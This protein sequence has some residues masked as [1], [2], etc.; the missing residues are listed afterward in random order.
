MA[1]QL[2]SFIAHGTT[3]EAQKPS[4]GRKQP[5]PKAEL[6]SFA[7]PHGER[8]AQER[9]LC[10]GGGAIGWMRDKQAA[11]MGNE[12]RKMQKAA[13]DTDA[14]ELAKADA[15]MLFLL[16]RDGKSTCGDSELGRE[17]A[18]SS[19][20]ALRDWLQQGVGRLF[21]VVELG[22]GTGSAAA[23]VIAREARRT[24][25]LTIAI[26]T[27]PGEAEGAARRQKAL[28]GLERLTASAD[29]TIVVD[30]EQTG[31]DEAHRIML[32]MLTDLRGLLA[33]SPPSPFDWGSFHALFHE[34]GPTFVLSAQARGAGRIT[35]ALTQI[36]AS[37]LLDGRNIFTAERLHISIQ[38][39]R[40]KL[41]VGEM[42]ECREW[43]ARFSP[44]VE[45]S[46]TMHTDEELDRSARIIVI[47]ARLA[48]RATQA[49]YNPSRSARDEDSEFGRELYYGAR[50]TSPR[51][52]Y[53]FTP[54]SLDNDGVI[55]LVAATPTYLRRPKTITQINQ[56][57]TKSIEI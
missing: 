8:D 25:L 39:G 45:L 14:D 6:L 31:D 19:L 21:M 33:T 30:K 32:Q 57:A 17:L 37:P 18:E 10:V 34:A 48:A 1:E 11:I 55:E 38:T 56:I 36:A 13:V 40:N 53:R 42:D 23:A 43:L 41:L 16:G 50:T 22:G 27:L 12:A 46:Y 28:R 9:L 24:G 51:Y 29:A 35:D 7:L 2:L 4:S 47:A 15:D 54:Q 20:D 44:R 49:A 26:A 5:M 3:A 52:V